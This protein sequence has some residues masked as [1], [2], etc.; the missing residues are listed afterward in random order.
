MQ[1]RLRQQ[2]GEADKL[3]LEAQQER[4]KLSQH[5]STALDSVKE[6]EESLQTSRCAYP[7]HCAGL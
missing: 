3:R 2:E 4:D 7:P 1:A 6:L 5:L